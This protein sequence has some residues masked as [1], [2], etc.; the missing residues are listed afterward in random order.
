[1]KNV[2]HIFLLVC[3]I[4]GC[5][6][7]IQEPKEN[8][9]K[10]ELNIATN[11]PKPD[12]LDLY[13]EKNISTWKEYETLASF[14]KIYDEISPN[15]A[16]NNAIELRDLVRDLKISDKPEIV[17]N[18][19]FKTRI[20]VLENEVLRLTDM[21]YISVISAEEVNTQVL[22]LIEVF[23]SLNQKI[24]TLYA[25]Q[26]F[27]EAVKIEDKLFTNDTIPVKIEKTKNKTVRNKSTRNRTL[28]EAILDEKSTTMK[29]KKKN[30]QKKIK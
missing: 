23:S 27:E 2:T 6:K 25:Q 16:L 11:Y 15:E 14:F 17:D 20:N 26:R 30:D 7:D 12:A 28:N 3:F 18:N 1:M 22:K 19:A 29:K 13:S 10:P 5:K 9:K 24:S 4:F 8:I 21:T